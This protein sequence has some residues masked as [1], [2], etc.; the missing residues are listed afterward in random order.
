MYMYIDFQGQIITAVWGESTTFNRSGG[1]CV[2][3]D[4]VLWPV[5]QITRII[6]Q[7]DHYTTVST[8]SKSFHKVQ[9]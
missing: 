4:P 9:S 3:I 1:Y 2:K 7:I 8:G 6:N 5:L